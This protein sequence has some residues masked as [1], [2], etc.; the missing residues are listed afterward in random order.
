MFCAHVNWHVFFDSEIPSP[1]LAMP[2]AIEPTYAGD[3]S[4]NKGA[5]TETL[6]KGAHEID[7]VIDKTG[8]MQPK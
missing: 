8:S 1:T 6:N 7:R 3:P 2:P 4:D 5:V